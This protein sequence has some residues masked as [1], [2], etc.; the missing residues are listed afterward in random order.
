MCWL[1]PEPR[2][3]ALKHNNVWLQQNM[4]CSHQL[5]KPSSSAVAGP[6]KPFGNGFERICDT[7]YQTH[8]KDTAARWFCHETKPCA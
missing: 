7:L 2:V 5:V 3:H 6:K 8:V 4:S 1:H